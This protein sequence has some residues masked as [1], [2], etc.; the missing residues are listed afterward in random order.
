M[1]N[2][3]MQF[4]PQKD[5]LY[6]GTALNVLWMHR[7]TPLGVLFR[8]DSAMTPI[9]KGKRRISSNRISHHTGIKKQFRK[10]AGGDVAAGLEL[11]QPEHTPFDCNY[12]NC[13]FPAREDSICMCNRSS[14]ETDRELAIQYSISESKVFFKFV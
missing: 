7:R 8:E 13:G 14:E 3:W 5:S 11:K 2:Q 6:A 12:V 10:N 9:E 1:S 4:F